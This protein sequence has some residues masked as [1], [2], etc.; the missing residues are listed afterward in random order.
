MIGFPKEGH[1]EQSYALS[2]DTMEFEY[3][4]VDNELWSYLELESW[5]RYNIVVI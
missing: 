4:G 2:I 3:V 1:I 5:N